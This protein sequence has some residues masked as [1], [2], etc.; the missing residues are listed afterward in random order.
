LSASA[1]E[2][3]EALK[4]MSH[5]ALLAVQQLGTVAGRL[6]SALHPHS[7]GSPGVAHSLPPVSGR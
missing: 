6:Q 5:D 3:L 4:L 1:G 2:Q 7:S